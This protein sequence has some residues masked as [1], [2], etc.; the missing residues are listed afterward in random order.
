MSRVD[1]EP[2]KCM[3]IRMCMS[4]RQEGNKRCKY[5]VLSYMK[6]HSTDLRKT[7]LSLIAQNTIVTGYELTLSARSLEA[8]LFSNSVTTAA[9]PSRAAHISAVQPSWCIIICHIDYYI[10]YTVIVYC[11][12]L[13][14]L[15]WRSSLSYKSSFFLF[16]IATNS[17]L[18][19]TSQTPIS[20][21]FHNPTHDPGQLL[22]PNGIFDLHLYYDFP[23]RF[24]GRVAFLFLHACPA[25]FSSSIRLTRILIVYALATYSLMHLPYNASYSV[26]RQQLQ[27]FDSLSPFLPFFTIPPFL[28]CL[29]PSQAC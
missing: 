2:N 10:L 26:T 19:R 14:D 8:P 18:F 5:L 16:P 13:T 21:N 27:S 29:V 23:I 6:S 24:F 1:V 11:V 7:F 22:S 9:C 17:P 3:C 12:K 20:Y 4:I 25:S 28:S 15:K